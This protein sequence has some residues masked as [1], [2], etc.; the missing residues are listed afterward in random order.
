MTIKTS[1]LDFANIKQSLIEHFQ[2]SDDFNDYDF[3]GSGL[4]SLLDVL[5]YNTHINGLT[6]NMAINESFLSSSQIRSSVLAHAE[7]LGY[8]TKS[9][10]G[11]TALVNLTIDALP[12]EDVLTIPLYHR[13]SADVDEVAFTFSTQEQYTA[14][15]ENDQFFFENVRIHEGATKSNTFIVSDEDSAYVIADKNID[16]STMLVKVFENFNTTSYTT[17][18]NIESSVTIG[19]E[20]RVYIVKEVS[21]GY[22]EIFF[23]DGNV[24]GTTPAV[25]SKVQVEYLQ[26][27][28]PESNGAT[29]FSAEFLNGR[30]ITVETVSK[31]SGGSERESLSQIKK[32]AP[33]AYTAQQRLVT[34]ADY[35]NLIKSK[36]SE[37]IN[38]VV[39]WG[40]HDNIPPEFGKVFV[41]LNFNEGT[42]E[43]K[44]TATE[45]L[46]QD[47]LTS[48]LAIMS[49][50]TKFVDPQETFLELTCRFNLDPTKSETPEAMQVAVKNIIKTHFNSS[51][52]T[53]DAVFRRSNLLKD[54]DDLSSAILNSRLDVV[55]QQRVLIENNNQRDYT[56][57]FPYAIA[58]PD[59]DDYTVKTSIFKYQGQD[60]YIKNVLGSN[61]LQIFDLSNVVRERNIGCYEPA[62]GEVFFTALSVD[63]LN[64]I[65]LKVSVTPANTST[66]RPLR[67]YIIMLDED[68]LSANAVID[69]QSTRVLL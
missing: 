12:L 26:T 1:D 46:I 39:A 66:V 35:E 28:G 36:F 56:I 42:D 65:T 25:G 64:P 68:A 16:T 60:V 7:A 30:P 15:K 8:T 41:S 38:D 18:I 23:S 14:Y 3:D 58:A 55:G 29:L 51:L 52:E 62:T 57:N 10:T 45:T 21:N 11:S 69:T 50:D 61:R 4:S 27:R 2:Q 33:R 19:D 49:I 54:I 32:N 40:G 48:N 47:N 17:Y 6:A 9:R 24:L 22:F 31:S 43:Q 20:S 59:K 34:A 63:T 13:F 5:A 37:Y 67:N 44:K 53:F